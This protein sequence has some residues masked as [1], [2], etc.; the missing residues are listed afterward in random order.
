M[1]E[2]EFAE[3][4]A[5]KLRK[6]L[7][8]MEVTTGESLIYKVI[9]DSD[10]NFYPDNPEKPKRGVMAFQ[11]DVLIKQENVPL[12]VIETKYGG[13]STHDVLTYSTKAMKHKEIYPY[14]RYGFVVGGYGVL[15]NRFFNHNSAFDFAMA[16][17]DKDD[18][19][20]LVSVVERQIL[21]SKNLIKIMKNK[22]HIKAYITNVEVW[23]V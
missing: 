6:H 7:P 12:I 17:D 21:N 22:N 14:L 10:M 15:N 19:N 20:D 23:H 8:S 5:S 11:T 2:R 9:I 4:V 3:K 1:N 13:F 16:I 18:L